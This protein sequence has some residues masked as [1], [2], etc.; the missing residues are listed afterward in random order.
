[1]SRAITIE[2]VDQ[3]GVLYSRG[4]FVDLISGCELKRVVDVEALRSCDGKENRIFRF[5]RRCGFFDSNDIKVELLF[6]FSFTLPAE[7]SRDD[8]GLKLFI[9]SRFLCFWYHILF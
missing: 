7:R 5:I 2:F 3:R 6:E 4:V 1:M 8:G 9:L